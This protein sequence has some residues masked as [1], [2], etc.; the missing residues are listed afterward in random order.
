MSKGTKVSLIY[1]ALRSKLLN[2]IRHKTGGPQ[3]AYSME[4]HLGA[5][6]R[7]RGCRD[8]RQVVNRWHTL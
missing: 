4:C 7:R 1:R 5:P 8:T 2:T 3:M 6:A